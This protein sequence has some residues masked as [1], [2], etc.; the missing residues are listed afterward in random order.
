VIG[1]KREI[2]TSI[3]PFLQDAIPQAV[4]ITGKFWNLAADQKGAFKSSGG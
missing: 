3:D 2:R 4:I 1:G